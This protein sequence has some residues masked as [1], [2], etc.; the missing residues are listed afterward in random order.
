MAGNFLDIEEYA[1][2]ENIINEFFWKVRIML[3]LE[4]AILS[5]MR[6]TKCWSGKCLK[7]SETQ[8]NKKAWDVRCVVIGVLVLLIMVAGAAAAVIAHRFKG[9]TFIIVYL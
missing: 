1:K 4:H 9:W 2:F 6:L 7:V 5:H 8:G 3:C